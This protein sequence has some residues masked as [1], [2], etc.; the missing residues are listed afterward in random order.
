MENDFQ[1]KYKPFYLSRFKLI[2]RLIYHF[3]CCF[4]LFILQLIKCIVYPCT[5]ISQGFEQ[6]TIESEGSLRSYG[7]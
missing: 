3:Y 6:V 1:W 2:F 4:F 5:T 7:S